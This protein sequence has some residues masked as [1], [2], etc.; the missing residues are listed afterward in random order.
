MGT[1]WNTNKYS[2]FDK[3]LL[4]KTPCRHIILISLSIFCMMPGFSQTW[5]RT[6][7]TE[8]N[9][10]LIE[11][12]KLHSP[13]SEHSSV[14]LLNL[15]PDDSLAMKFSQLTLSSDK[16]YFSFYPSFH[17]SAGLLRE[18]KFFSNNSLG[19]NA[20]V[21]Y[22]NSGHT[23]A[24]H[25]GTEIFA[26]VQPYYLRLLMRE[27]QLVPGYM[28]FKNINRHWNLAYLPDLYLHYQ[29]PWIVNLEAGIG[30]Q[31]IGDGYRSLFIS[32]NSSPYPYTRLG[33]DFNNV[34]YQ[35]NWLWLR[36]SDSQSFHPRPKKFAL[37][38]YLSWNI[39]KRISVGLF[40]SIVW[41]KDDRMGYEL[42]YLNP[43][44]FY[45]PVEYSI[46]SSDNV[47]LGL[48]LRIGLVKNLFFY[49]QFL[50][51]DMKT[52]E[53]ANDIRHRLNPDDE[54]I[55]YGWFAN[56]YAGQAGLKYHDA[57]G[58]INLYLQT[59]INAV[60]PFV[61]AHNDVSQTYT[62]VYQALAHPLGSNFAEILFRI[63]YRYRHYRVDLLGVH[64]KSGLSDR[65]NNQGENI[66][67]PVSDGSNPNYITAS[68]Y[69]NEIMQGIP[70]D[71]LYLKADICWIVTKQNSLELFIS[72]FYRKGWES[73]ATE[74]VDYGV[75]VGARTHPSWLSN[76]F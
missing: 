76:I 75:L 37:I 61:Y 11:K 21:A 22:N 57:F 53:L 66:F 8:S 50:I 23:L 41:T 62:H 55:N 64:A 49:G 56:K 36:N 5:L 20:D 9:R 6:D 31:F 17:L 3:R 45:R 25:A 29:S 26:G 58:L 74:I 39:H 52:G 28:S 65:N 60:R 30:K 48:N 35:M 18:T 38:H 7:I 71:L 69:G 34:H 12:R 15:R 44:I 10:L 46:G 32:R 13:L 1:Y 19:F 70:V 40:E 43:F 59:E 33:A 54:T 63:G 14:N 51:D 73:C 72:G 2:P 27:R 68:T 16:L 24:M 67:Y 42:Q 47:L 4:M